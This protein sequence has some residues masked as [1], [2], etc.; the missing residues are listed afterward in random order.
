MVTLELSIPLLGPELGVLIV[1]LTPGEQRHI[2]KRDAVR[3]KP[4]EQC[5]VDDKIDIDFQINWCIR[6]NR[7]IHKN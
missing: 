3:S 2:A 5:K 1:T 6:C 4:P 7:N